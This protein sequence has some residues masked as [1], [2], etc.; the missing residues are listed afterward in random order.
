[1][2]FVETPQRLVDRDEPLQ[3]F[4][5]FGLESLVIAALAHDCIDQHPSVP[6]GLDGQLGALPHQPRMLLP[7][8]CIVGLAEHIGHV[9]LRI[10]GLFEGDP[11]EGEEPHHAQQVA[12]SRVVLPVLLGR[13]E[14]AIVIAVVDMDVLLH[15]QPDEGEEAGHVLE[16]LVIILDD[17]YLFFDIREGD[18]QEGVKR[19]EDEAKLIEYVAELFE[20]D[21]LLGDI[22]LDKRL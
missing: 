2:L 8:G 9:L 5:I 13:L 15:L 14:G 6:R 21:L 20:K 7:E 1:M 22:L 3:E 10:S 19:L 18:P 11:D 12:G 17:R 4:R 16:G